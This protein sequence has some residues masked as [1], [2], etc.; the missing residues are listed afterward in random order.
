MPHS[1]HESLVAAQQPPPLDI[2]SGS[3]VSVKMIDSTTAMKLP[4]SL[5]M[6][7]KIPGHDHL[8]CP[9]YSFLIEHPSGRKLLYDLGTRKDL[10]NLAPSILDMINTPGWEF[11][12]ERD[13]AE[14]LEENGVATGSIEAVIWSHWHC[15]YPCAFRMPLC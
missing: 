8:H 1:D 6:G 13:V 3:T 12:V 2:S 4:L 11:K 7:P 5:I 10:E 15:E 14:I 9:A